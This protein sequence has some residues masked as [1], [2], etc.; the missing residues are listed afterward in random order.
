MSIRSVGSFFWGSAKICY[1]L[2]EKMNN[3]V[4]KKFE[5]PKPYYKL[6]RD[7]KEYLS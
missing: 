5:I 2:A 4:K 7:E 1:N 3:L 6:I